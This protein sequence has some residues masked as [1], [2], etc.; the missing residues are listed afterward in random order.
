[1]H[2]WMSTLE[3]GLSIPRTLRRL[4]NREVRLQD[5]LPVFEI[6]DQI[7]LAEHRRSHNAVVIPLRKTATMITRQADFEISE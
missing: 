6:E 4:R 3:T 2:S 1:M 7:E 5:Q